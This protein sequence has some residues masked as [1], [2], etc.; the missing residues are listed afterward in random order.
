MKEDCERYIYGASNKAIFFEAMYDR[1][2]PIHDRQSRLGKQFRT[3]Y[4]VP[5]VVFS[6]VCNE[7]EQ[8]FNPCSWKRK[9]KDVPIKLRIMACLRQL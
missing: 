5:W 7:I 1:D 4:G 8:R 9:L 6:N 2:S 3:D